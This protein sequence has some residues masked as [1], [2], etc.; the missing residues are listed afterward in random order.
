MWLS[1]VDADCVSNS[2]SVLFGQINLCCVIL[3]I[4]V[5]AVPLEEVVYICL[6]L[7]YL[8][9]WVFMLSF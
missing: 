1:Y 5:P 6:I 9:F 3:I 8:Y 7:E 4:L 2:I